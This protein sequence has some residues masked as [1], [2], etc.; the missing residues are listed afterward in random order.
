MHFVTVTEK[1]AKKIGEEL[2]NSFNEVLEIQLMLLWRRRSFQNERGESANYTIDVDTFTREWQK[3][4]HYRRHYHDKDG[5]KY[6]NCM[7]CGTSTEPYRPIFYM[8]EAQAE[9]LAIDSGRDVDE[10]K[11]ELESRSWVLT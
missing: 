11:R 9:Q 6:P 10:F 7:G 4:R 1:T 3:I 2:G 5:T 8:P